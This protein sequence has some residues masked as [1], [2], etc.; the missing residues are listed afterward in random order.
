[1]EADILY[2]IYYQCSL[3]L[4]LHN[5]QFAYSAWLSNPRYVY[6][7]DLR[8]CNGGNKSITRL[9]PSGA[10]PFSLSSC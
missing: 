4:I 7:R 2:E 5:C 3:L 9:K 8:G 10:V 1:M 6:E